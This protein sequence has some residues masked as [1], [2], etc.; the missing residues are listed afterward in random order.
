M[1]IDKTNEAKENVV[2]LV[3]PNLMA[4]MA[5]ILKNKVMERHSY[6]QMKYFI[7][8]KEPTTQA[9]L[10]QCLRE[11]KT[12]FEALEAVALEIEEGKDNLELINIKIDKLSKKIEKYEENGETTKRELEIDLRKL[13]R[14]KIAA[15]RNIQ[16]LQEKKKSLEDESRFFV[17]TFKSLVQ[18]E[19]L[20][21]FDD[22]DSQC[23]YWGERLQSKLNLK[24]ITQGTLDTD[25][26]ETILALPDRIPVKENTL[27]SLE[28]RSQKMQMLL[29]Q[30]ATPKE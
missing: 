4:D 22:F 12:R 19:P 18:T 3:A 25:L 26:I 5:E 2:E 15:F 9:K 16:K 20:K 10:W 8:H 6:F 11:I 17:E 29:D 14:K 28:F 23:E 24:M 13:G 30:S 27:K 7:I 1:S 21:P